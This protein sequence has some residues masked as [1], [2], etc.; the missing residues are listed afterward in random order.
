MDRPHDTTEDAQALLDEAE[1]QDDAT[2]LKA[3]ED[4]HGAL[5]KELEQDEPRPESGAAE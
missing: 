5:D 3:L 4:L 2:R 1:Q